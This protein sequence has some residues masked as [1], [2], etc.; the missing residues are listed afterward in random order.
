LKNPFRVERLPRKKLHTDKPQIKM[1][2]EDEG[3]ESD[4][5]EEEPDKK[6]GKAKRGTKASRGK[7]KK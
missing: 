1:E 6:K 3:Y 4:I 7:K 5:E 2:K